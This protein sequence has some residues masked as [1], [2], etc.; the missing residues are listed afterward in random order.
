MFSKPNR[1]SSASSSRPDAPDAPRKAIACSLIA[2]NVSLE[3]DLVSEGDVQLDGSV[4]G[5]L[6]LNHLT[7]GETGQVDGLITAEAVEVRGRVAGAITAKT[8]RL[9]ATARVDG[10]ITHA[11]LAVDAGAHFA[12]RSIK[13]VPAVPEQ[14]SLVAEAAE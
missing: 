10:D 1:P 13:L 2:E 8:V 14:L 12:G 3:G 9:Y 11:Q 4:R 7:V 5:D 6:K